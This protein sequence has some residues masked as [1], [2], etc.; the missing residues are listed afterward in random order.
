MEW[1]EYS[2]EHESL[3]R[4]HQ[5]VGRTNDGWAL[6]TDG[7]Q[8]W[9]ITQANTIWHFW[10]DNLGDLIYDELLSIGCCDSVLCG[11]QGPQLQILRYLKMCQWQTNASKGTAQGFDLF[12]A[13]Q[14]C[15]FP[16]SCQR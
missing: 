3:F 14:P 4:V 5:V 9:D 6:V 1:I 2:P 10:P 12:E 8:T 13:V 15:Q 11:Q 7:Y 16:F